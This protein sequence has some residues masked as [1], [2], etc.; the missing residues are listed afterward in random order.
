MKIAMIQ[1][2]PVL[3]NK[4][5]SIEKTISL[6]EKAENA[7]LIVFPES[8]IPCYPRGL[9]FG[10]HIGGADAQGRQDYQRYYDSSVEITEL[11][12]VCD[13]AKRANAI[14]SLGIT[15]RDGG[16]LYCTNVF[17]G[18]DGKL[19]GKHRKIKPTGAERCVW[20]EGSDL[21]TF[22]SPFGT[23]GSLICWENYMPLARTAMY[24]Q[25]IDIYIAPNAD[26]RREWQSTVRH[27]AQEG[28]CFVLSCNQFVKKSD[29]PVDLQSRLDT[30]ADEISPGGSCV[31]A[32]NG[33]YLREPL[34]HK[35]EII[36]CE[37][38]S[39]LLSASRLDFDPCGH[40]SRPD[41]FSFEYKTPQF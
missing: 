20:G 15:E 25:G 34:Y 1:D 2:A 29:Y 40:Y 18:S 27:I 38:D 13:A 32:P 36:T 39:N 14:V 5:G 35:A 37:L 11:A 12:P 4:R 8:F 3:F 24:S 6:I 10:M 41:L 23:I 33:K 30:P 17:I 9:S 21:F 7:D 22:R 19:L 31:I 16:T 26:G 28:R